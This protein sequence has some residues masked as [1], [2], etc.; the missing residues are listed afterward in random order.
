[1]K[2]PDS[3]DVFIYTMLLVPPMVIGS[4]IILISRG[5]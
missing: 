5:F 1:M 3:A 4:I 2:I